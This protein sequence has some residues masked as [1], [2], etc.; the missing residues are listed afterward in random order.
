MEGIHILGL[1]NLGKYVAYA[2]MQR[3]QQAAARQMAATGSAAM[4]R[5]II[6][7]APTL[8]FH[9][10]GLLAD[11]EAS[12]RSI[13]CA[14]PNTRVGSSGA[15]ETRSEGFHVELLAGATSANPE[16]EGRSEGIKYL[17]VATKAHA[18]AAALAPLRGRL[19]RG[20]HILFLQNGMGKFQSPAPSTLLGQADLTR[21]SGVSDEVST[22]VFV[23]QTIRPTYWTGICSAGVYSESPFSIVHAGRGPLTIGMSE[24]LS[25][26]V[27]GSSPQNPMAAQLLDAAILET[28]VVSPDEI[29][30]AQ[31]KKLVINSVVN[32][33]TA[34]Y[35]CKNGEV[36]DS[37][38]ARKVADQL[39]QEAGVIIRAILG[40]RSEGGRPTTL[41]AF[42]DEKLHEYVNEV[43]QKT[44]NN[45][46]SML[47]D[48]QA[49]RQTEIDYINGYLVQQ[50]K[51]MGLPHKQHEEIVQMIKQQ[52]RCKQDRDA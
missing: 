17:V 27:P 47:Q 50:A 43:V 22:K 20:S 38:V 13:R 49:G 10:S 16:L 4:S 15:G 46:S 7:P 44:A 24:T 48:V 6:F 14:T 36:F 23:D 5:P 19:N 52:S 39:L 42:T 25:H 21:H 9:R 35:K 40:S 32:P 3:C 11:W 34:L 41:A 18:T 33:L 31:L 29:L 2:L 12:G 30:Q 26:A 1:G 51:S 28:S 8:L 45:T 37:A